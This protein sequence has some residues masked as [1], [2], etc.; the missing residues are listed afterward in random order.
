M[1]KIEF[2]NILSKKIGFVIVK[3]INFTN[4]F[5]DFSSFSLGRLKLNS[6]E[7]NFSH[8]S[9]DSVIL[10]IN[11]WKILPERSFNSIKLFHAKLSK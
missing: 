6:F 3:N 7:K 9:G 11:F 1:E 8:S 10:S 5:E 4:T 2:S